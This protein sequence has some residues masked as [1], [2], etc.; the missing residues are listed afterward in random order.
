MNNIKLFLDDIRNPKD[1]VNYMHNRIG[2]LNPIYLEE[3]FVVKNYQDFVAYLSVKY[4]QITHISLDHDLCDTHYSVN[5]TDSKQKYNNLYEHFIEKTGLDC[6]KYL[7]EFYKSKNLKLPII[8][9]HS[10]NPVGT[11]NIYNELK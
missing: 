10:M 1:C 7:K 11:L 5:D 2:K 4:K 8:F 9:I 3:W 6:A